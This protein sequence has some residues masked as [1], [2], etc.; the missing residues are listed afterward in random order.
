MP[1]ISG[2]ANTGG[3]VAFQTEQLPFCK[4]TP[5]WQQG[6]IDKGRFPH[7]SSARIE[8][9]FRLERLAHRTAKRGLG[10][11]RD[12]ILK[13]QDPAFKWCLVLPCPLPTPRPPEVP[14]K[15]HEFPT[16]ASLQ[17]HPKFNKTSTTDE[18]GIGS[19]PIQVVREDG[20]G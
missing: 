18:L 5:H 8:K 3:Q 10:Q 20:T 6:L 4:L 17:E 2:D 16:C 7:P 14:K 15:E 1:E 12:L 19:I 13:T 11:C 9:G